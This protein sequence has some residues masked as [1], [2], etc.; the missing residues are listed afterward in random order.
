MGLLNIGSAEPPTPPDLGPTIEELAVITQEIKN[1]TIP[2]WE[3]TEYIYGTIL[4]H[5]DELH[6]ADA[7]YAVEE[8]GLV[9]T[10]Y[11]FNG[12][13]N[14][15]TQKKEGWGCY[16]NN[17]T[18]NTTNSGKSCLTWIDGVETGLKIFHYYPHAIRLYEWKNGRDHGKSTYVTLD[19]TTGQIT[20]ADNLFHDYIYSP[21]IQIHNNPLED[22]DQ[23]FYTIVGPTDN[24]YE[25][26]E[27]GLLEIAP[28]RARDTR[29]E[30]GAC[31]PGK[32]QPHDPLDACAAYFA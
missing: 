12:Y 28:L 24:L 1:N 11:T 19:G 2:S 17:D 5:I 4:P 27:N 32:E 8:D 16:T 31:K 30:A 10:G 7:L 15:I 3:W 6:D 21:R 20:R 18:V 29:W 22:R 13:R 9:Y 14:K 23:A 25:D 26:G